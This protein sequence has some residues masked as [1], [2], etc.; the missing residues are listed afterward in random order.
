MQAPEK[1]EQRLGYTFTKPELLTQALTHRSFGTTNNERLEFLGDA[2]LNFIIARELF[3]RFP[4]AREG[5][6]SRLRA[7]LV[8]RQTLAEVA[9]EFSL[10]DYLIMGSGELKSGGFKR[11]SILSDSLEAIIGAMYLDSDIN[12]VE[13]R[14]T[15]WFYGRLDALS[16]KTSQKD[17]KSRLQEYLQAR[18][19]ELPEYVVVDVKGAAHAQKFQVECRTALLDEPAVGEGSS[20]RIAE[21]NAAGIALARLGVDH[22]PDHF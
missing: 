22:E 17:S 9:R 16:L 1:L 11:D 12:C 6:L 7:R 18:Q 5:Q 13:E 2:I 19:H 15:S 4:S 20:R 14:V 21:Q 3:D 10:G 8:R